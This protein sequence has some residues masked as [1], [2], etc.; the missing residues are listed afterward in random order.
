MWFQAKRKVPFHKAP[1]PPH[2]TSNI[3]LHVPMKRYNIADIPYLIIFT[4]VQH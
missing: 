2:L 1:P 4:S 3:K